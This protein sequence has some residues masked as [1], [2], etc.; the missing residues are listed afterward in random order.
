[1][2]RTQP[3]LA[4]TGVPRPFA[5][6]DQA[7]GRARRLLSAEA[8]MAWASARPSEQVNHARA[9]RQLGSGTWRVVIEAWHTR[10]DPAMLDAH[11]LAQL[12]GVQVRARRDYPG[13][14]FAAGLALRDTLQETVTAVRRE[15]A[16]RT[17]ETLRQH[18]WRA[19]FEALLDGRSM[20]AAARA[21]GLRSNA[22]RSR[23]LYGGRDLFV[24][25]FLEMAGAL[26]APLRPSIQREAS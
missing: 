14:P 17:G 12:P 19:G 9:R 21:L 11:P 8:A 18:D 6:R 4:S 15:L 22:H 16:P 25:R 13:A 23:N 5:A 20:S 1:M 2:Q 10:D 24:R 7:I 3:N 26:N